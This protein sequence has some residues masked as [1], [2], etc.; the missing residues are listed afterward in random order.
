MG[1]PDQACSDPAVLRGT[2]PWMNWPNLVDWIFA[3][4]RLP[5]PRPE[6]CGSTAAGAT[7]HRPSHVALVRV[8][9]RG[10]RSPKA[11]RRVWPLE[12]A[13]RWNF[14]FAQARHRIRRARPQARYSCGSRGLERRPRRGATL[15]KK[16]PANVIALTLRRADIA[17]RRVRWRSYQD[18]IEPEGLVFIE[19]QHRDQMARKSDRAD[20]ATSLRETP[21]ADRQNDPHRNCSYPRRMQ[22]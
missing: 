1:I 18:R 21:V 15:Q 17:P 7:R 10:W 20:F 13:R 8:R 5:R 11:T 6:P 12:R 2:G 3:G 9:H 19:T 22:L 4:A 14:A 16:G